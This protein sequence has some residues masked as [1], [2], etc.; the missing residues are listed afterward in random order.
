M[1]SYPSRYPGE[2]RPAVLTG[3]GGPR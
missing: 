2:I 1:R 3:H